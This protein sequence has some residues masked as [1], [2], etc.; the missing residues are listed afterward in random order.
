MYVGRWEELPHRSPSIAPEMYPPQAFGPC[1]V[2]FFAPAGYRVLK[3]CWCFMKPQ[4]ASKHPTSIKAGRRPKAWLYIVSWQL[5][6]D[7]TVVSCYQE[8][9]IK[10]GMN[11]Q[12]HEAF[13]EYKI[14]QGAGHMSWRPNARECIRRVT[15][16]G[17]G[18]LLEKSFQLRLCWD[19]QAE[20]L[21]ARLLRL[22]QAD[23]P[24]WVRLLFA[25]FCNCL[26]KKTQ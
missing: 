9:G 22:L 18:S 17:S 12:L 19:L 21:R 23:G 3:K 4:N 16:K 24:T 2:D 10:S 13:L 25:R 5:A 20:E 26:Q 11:T 8:W 15:D 1:T 14:G 7:L 6:V